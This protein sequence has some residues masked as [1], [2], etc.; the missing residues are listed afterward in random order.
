MGRGGAS[1]VRT[2]KHTLG[3]RRAEHEFSH[4][5]VWALAREGGAGAGHI[6]RG[7]KGELGVWG[8]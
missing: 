4:K 3:W 8:G 7:G 5:C 2:G 1:A 6:G